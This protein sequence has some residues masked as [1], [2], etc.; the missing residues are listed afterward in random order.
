MWD[1]RMCIDLEVYKF[2][3]SGLDSVDRLV[4][5]DL[6]VHPFENFSFS[7][8]A[9]MKETGTQLDILPRSETPLDVDGEASGLPGLSAL[10]GKEYRTPV[11]LSCL[12]SVAVVTWSLYSNLLVPL[13][14][15][16]PMEVNSSAAAS[17]ID[18]NASES[19]SST[20]TQKPKDYTLGG[21]LPEPSEFDP[22]VSCKSRS[23]QPHRK[24]YFQPSNELIRRLRRYEARHGKCADRAARNFFQPSESQDD[25]CRYVVWTQQSGFGNRLI[26]LTSA[27]LYALLTDR[28]LLVERTEETAVLFCEPFPSG[29]WLLP[30][31]FTGELIYSLDESSPHRFAH[32]FTNDR[33]RGGSTETANF[34]YIHLTWTKDDEDKTF[35]CDESQVQLERVP[36]IFMRADNYLVPSYF[37][38]SR[39]SPDLGALFPDK[40]A[41]FNLLGNY[42]FQ[43]SDVAWGRITRYYRY[44]LAD[45]DRLLGIQ[46]RTYQAKSPLPN[47]SE[48]LQ[49]CIVENNLLPKVVVD[50]QSEDISRLREKKN[51]T[52]G[53]LITSLDS[54]Y[55]DNLQEHY[56]S[57]RVESGESVAVD[58]PSHEEAQL[59][60]ISSHDL[61][62][63][64]EIYLLSLSDSLIISG[65]S[66]FGYAAH[67]LAGIRPWILL[68]VNDDQVHDPPCIYGK[69]VEP[70]DFAFPIG[71]FKCPSE[72]IPRDT[73]IFP[74]VQSCDDWES[75]GKLVNE[76]STLE[77]R[78]QFWRK[79]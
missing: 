33:A 23:Q 54:Y 64:A 35:F 48:Q 43:P 47:F 56:L 41:V 67:A 4:Q 51:G 45:H 69:S 57:G 29:S 75:G 22:G 20:E 71:K 7:G 31:E 28:T 60:G 32:N 63:W 52:T 78:T 79:H 44:Y 40:E 73:N 21:L 70:C 61:K 36:W 15:Q 10:K 13:V 3:R 55:Y 42:L 34:S 2:S 17:R 14:R 5:A 18:A 27:F 16:S 39:F 65:W 72:D 11:L 74:Y 24:N 12:L 38:I 8:Q 19:R 9:R 25:D 66:T 1:W 26:T 62:A 46:I 58:Q 50:G 68:N 77:D 76:S 6:L 49:K 30:L 59:T 53:V 37:F